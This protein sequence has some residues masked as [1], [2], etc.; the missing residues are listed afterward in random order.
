[1]IYIVDLFLNFINV[2]VRIMIFKIFY[3]LTSIAEYF[4]EDI[5]VSLSSPSFKK[6][7]N[8]ELF[9]WKKCLVFCSSSF[10]G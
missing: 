3:G 5:Q 10:G 4:T 8:E 7:K 9:Y 1:M 6:V 2:S